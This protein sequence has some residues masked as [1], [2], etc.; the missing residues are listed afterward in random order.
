MF[1]KMFHKHEF[2]TFS[3][4]LEDLGCPDI[5]QGW[6]RNGYYAVAYPKNA[7]VIYKVCYCGAYHVEITDGAQEYKVN[8]NYILTKVKE[9]KKSKEDKETERLLNLGNPDYDAISK[10]DK[11]IE[12]LK[13]LV[14]QLKTQIYNYQEQLKKS[15][16]NDA[17][18]EKMTIT[19]KRKFAKKY[20]FELKDII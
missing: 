8:E 7:L 17:I 20:D 15:V 3:C 18:W 13:Q 1:K 2:T 16:R 14:E 12:G 19:E 5:K 10:R 4:T 11:E 9:L 6:I